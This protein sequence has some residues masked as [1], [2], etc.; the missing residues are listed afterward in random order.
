MAN[1]PNPP[2]VCA[3]CPDFQPPTVP[4]ISHGMCAACAARIAAEL[5]ELD[6]A[7]DRKAAA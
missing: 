2:T 4:G 1:T 7:A 5:A 6:Q 3:W